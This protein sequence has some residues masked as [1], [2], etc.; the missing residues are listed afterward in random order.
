MKFGCK[1]YVV[2]VVSHEDMRKF[3]LLFYETSS[4]KTF[5]V[6]VSKYNLHL[7]LNQADFKTDR[8]EK[9]IFQSIKIDNNSQIRIG[10]TYFTPKILLHRKYELEPADNSFFFIETCLVVD[11]ISRNSSLVFDIAKL[12]QFFVYVRLSF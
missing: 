3:A 7:V 6:Y 5:L 10:N 4:K 8:V 2:T 12:D 11:S 1:Y 9:R